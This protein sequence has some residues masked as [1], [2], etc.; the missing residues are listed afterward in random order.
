MCKARCVNGRHGTDISN[1]KISRNAFV[2][3]YSSKSFGEVSRKS[4]KSVHPI[5]SLKVVAFLPR[6]NVRF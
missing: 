6:S 5:N 1:I 4:V 3:H 2:Y